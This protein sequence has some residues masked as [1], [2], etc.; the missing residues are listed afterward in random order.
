MSEFLGAE[1]NILRHCSRFTEVDGGE[2]GKGRI[3]WCHLRN[4]SASA[5]IESW[6][7]KRLSVSSPP[8]SFSVKGLLFSRFLSKQNGMQQNHPGQFLVC[9]WKANE[10]PVAPAPFPK[11]FENSQKE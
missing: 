7:L 6:L 4:P 1:M 9:K 5:I 11:I 2:Q 8:S 10:Y 3:T